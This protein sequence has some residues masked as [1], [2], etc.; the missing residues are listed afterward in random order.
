MLSKTEDDTACLNPKES[1]PTSI[2][3]M[4]E[5]VRELSKKF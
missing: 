3:Q 1:I 5:K 4:E 2:G